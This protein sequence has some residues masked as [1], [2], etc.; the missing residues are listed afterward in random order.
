MAV[1]IVDSRVEV[2]RIDGNDNEVEWKQQFRYEG[3]EWGQRTAE[4]LLVRLYYHPCMLTQDRAEAHSV[5]GGKKRG[6]INK[7]Y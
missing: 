6:H 5:S 4:P 1:I 3:F 7:P 2:V